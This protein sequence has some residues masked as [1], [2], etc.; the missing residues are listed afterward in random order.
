MAN[1]P[2]RTSQPPCS[3][4]KPLHVAFGAR[5]S[6]VDVVVKRSRVRY[7]GSAEN[8]PSVEFVRGRNFLERPVQVRYT[9]RHRARDR[10]QLVVVDEHY[11]PPA[12]TSRPRKTRSTKTPSKRWLPSTNAR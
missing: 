9:E 7:R 12:R 6:E 2:I 3:G 8:G 1:A 11:P 4:R 10:R 5:A